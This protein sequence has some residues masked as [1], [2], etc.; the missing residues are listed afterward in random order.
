M[1]GTWTLG[2]GTAVNFCKEAEQAAE[3]G[4]GGPLP[5][6]GIYAEPL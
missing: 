6:A 3:Q 4:G 5:G 2:L 1:L